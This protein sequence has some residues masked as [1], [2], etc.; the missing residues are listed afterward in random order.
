MRYME[1]NRNEKDKE[2]T[3][4]KIIKAVESIII[5]EGFEKLGINLIASKADVSKVLIYRYF[6]NIEDLIASYLAEN[7]FWAGFSVEFPKNENLRE[8]IK[9]LFC[10]QLTQMRQNKIMQHIQRW[11]LVTQNKLTEKL[12]LKREAKSITLITIIS[13]LA[14]CDQE[15]AAAFFTILSSSITYLT[16]FSEVCPV[17][18]GIDLQT[19]A[20]WE[21]I[22]NSIYLLIDNWIDS[23]EKK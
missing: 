17:Y 11:E 10:T 15:E 22:L 7:D 8:F 3:Q 13:H 2:N 18:N 12:K 4:K 19:D 16:M 1:T 21:R 5:D 9:Q 23:I 6:G 20:D 14:Q